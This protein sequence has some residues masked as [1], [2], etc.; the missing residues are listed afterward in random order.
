MWEAR[1]C[2]GCLNRINQRRLWQELD[3]DVNKLL[4][5]RRKSNNW[6]SLKVFILPINSSVIT[7]CSHNQK[8]RVYLPILKIS[9]CQHIYK[10]KWK[11]S[12]EFEIVWKLS[13][14]SEEN[15]KVS[16]QVRSGRRRDGALGRR[17][18]REGG[19]GE[20]G[21]KSYCVTLDNYLSLPWDSLL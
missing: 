4:L 21:Q 17:W 5:Q 18:D 7:I 15:K 8:R 1:R 13:Q 3:A 14:L 20:T 16:I 2:T 11:S 10:L 6:N 12:R 9:S 19:T